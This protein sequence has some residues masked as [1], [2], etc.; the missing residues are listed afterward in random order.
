[1]AYTGPNYGFNMAAKRAAAKRERAKMGGV[2]LEST[3]KRVI[4]EPSLNLWPME[5]HSGEVFDHEIIWEANGE[6]SDVLSKRLE[7]S[8]L[9]ILRLPTG[10]GKTIL[11]IES[12]GKYQADLGES[13]PFIVVVPRAVL[14]RKGWQK[15]IQAWNNDHPEN[16]LKPLMIETTDRFASICANSVTLRAT[17]K[18]LGSHGKL[19]I[20]EIHNYKNPTS[21]RSKKLQYLKTFN[22]LGLTAT[23][24][25]NDAVND[26]VS[27]LVMGGYYNSKNNF[28][29]VSRLSGLI[30]RRG[31][32]L[33]YDEDTHRVDPYRWAYYP[34]MQTELSQIIYAPEFDMSD[35]KMP[36]VRSKLI[37]LP[38][39]EVLDA[40][41]LSLFGAYRLGAFDS[42]VDY[43]MA[44]IETLVAAP[45]RLKSLVELVSADDAIQPLVFYWHTSALESIKKAFDDNSISYQIISGGHSAADVDLTSNSPIII[46][47]QSG[48]EGIEMPRSNMSVFYQNQNSASKLEQAKGRNVRRGSDHEVRQYS[49]LSDN[50]FDVRTFM[51]LLERQETSTHML[52]EIAVEASKSQFGASK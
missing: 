52:A 36:N 25:T 18:G 37:Q 29:E 28:Y 12:M 21:K 49:I 6:H 35:I 22:K 42:S 30:G 15:T 40:Q 32:L 51:R 3:P 45:E 1:M 43:M 8:S 5:S 10:L 14:D 26:G 48:S 27:Y 20:D 39:D 38:H 16:M 13:V 2:S 24:F 50:E 17:L 44:L 11:A 31:E 19:I 34:T 47:Y 41:T 4:P 46:Q 7:D 33:I 23:P 9:T